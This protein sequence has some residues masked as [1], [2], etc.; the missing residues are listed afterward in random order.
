MEPWDSA[1]LGGR[2]P[3]TWVSRPLPFVRPALRAPRERVVATWARLAE[4]EEPIDV[5]P[6]FLSNAVAKLACVDA[7]GRER[8]RTDYAGD[9]AKQV[10]RQAH[11][12]VEILRMHWNAGRRRS[13]LEHWLKVAPLPELFAF[14]GSAPSAEPLMSWAPMSN[15]LIQAICGDARQS[16]R[17]DDGLLA[18]LQMAAANMCGLEH[19]DGW[20]HAVRG[21]DRASLTP[22]AMRQSAKPLTD[23]EW[24]LERHGVGWHTGGQ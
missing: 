16:Y 7:A 15:G 9:W 22:A 14:R 11:S 5:A 13:V 10:S 17:L 19:L 6:S 1:R 4:V 21:T 23:E 8:V 20:L 18:D 3:E 2:R 12:A 24:L